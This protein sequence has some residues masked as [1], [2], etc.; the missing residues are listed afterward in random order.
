MT[1]KLFVLDL[2]KN[3]IKDTNIEYNNLIK[4]DFENEN[5]IAIDLYKKALKKI[6]ISKKITQKKVII[7][8][9]TNDPGMFFS[10]KILFGNKRYSVLTTPLLILDDNLN[11]LFKSQNRISSS[12]IHW[13]NNTLYFNEFDKNKSYLSYIT[14]SRNKTLNPYLFII[15]LT[16]LLIILLYFFVYHHINIPMVSTT[17]SYFIIYKFFGKLYYWKL[18]GRLKTI[19]K[20]PK[21]M[22]LNE[23]IPIDLLNEISDDNELRYQRSFF[24]LKYKV[25]EISSTDEFQIIQ[26]ISHD[27]KN[28]V[29]MTKLMTEQYEKDLKIKNKDFVENMFSSLKDI[30]SSAVMLSN[31]SHIN[32]LYKEKV[33]I[34]SFIEYIISQYVNHP[35]FER[36]K[37]I[38][39]NSTTNSVIELNI[40]KSLFQIAF[41]NLLNNALEAIDEKGYVK[42]EISEIKDDLVIEI[43]N[44]L[45]L[46]S[47]RTLSRV[48]DSSNL[49]LLAGEGRGEVDKIMEVG[50]S[51]K[52]KG[53]GL[54]IP[55]SKAII[56]RH[57]GTLDI[58]IKENEFIV[59]IIL[60]TKDT[61]IQ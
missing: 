8:E 54:G 16:E 14:F 21:K 49:P 44:S 61:P 48:G 22:S 55:I 25:Y 7:K 42:V 57:K 11:T 39:Q 38:T 10:N 12:S 50:F 36:I 23:E 19:Y 45:T 3:E 53:S 6:I 5:I 43:R 13:K 58:S 37:F 17:S 56:E 41:K 24:F 1:K 32:K 18:Q 60:A 15:I 4:F 2:K 9:V 33:E 20:L 51:T 31:F 30:S 26:R 52:E 29:L 34:K 47:T 28:Q 46:S 35:L 59:R 40:D 27:L